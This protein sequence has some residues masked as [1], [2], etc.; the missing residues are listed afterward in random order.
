MKLNK[1]FNGEHKVDITDLTVDEFVGI[2][3]AL[4][5]SGK[6]ELYNKLKELNKKKEV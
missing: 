2:L 4:K 3:G 1:Y 5:A 6:D